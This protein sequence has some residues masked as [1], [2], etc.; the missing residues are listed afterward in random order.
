MT[1]RAIAAHCGRVSGHVRASTIRPSRLSR[2]SRL[3]A[4]AL[5]SSRSHTCTDGEDSRPLESWIESIKS[6]SSLALAVPFVALPFGSLSHTLS[7]SLS[8]LTSNYVFACGFVGWF[9]AQ[10]AKIFTKWYKTKVFDPTAFFDSGGMPS[11]HSSLCAAMTTAVAIHHGLSSSLF[12]ACTCF[13][14]IVM[15]DAMGVRRHAGLQAQVLNAV[16]NSVLE[17]H[18][19]V[20]GRK[21]KEV[22]G[23]TPR[24][25]LM[26][27]L[28]GV[29][30]GL[31]FPH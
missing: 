25:V 14:V 23:H 8:E 18:P 19:T 17:D 24:Q 28:L 30:I 2:P 4:L 16:V 1:S 27:G 26:G 31:L 20:S 21:L 12:A 13:T 9:V 7:Q 29:C 6:S 11:S 5:S 10:A 3:V 22:L 15:Y